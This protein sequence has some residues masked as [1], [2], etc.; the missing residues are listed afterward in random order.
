MRVAY[1]QADSGDISL[2]IPSTF[3]LDFRNDRAEVLAAEADGNPVLTKATYGKGTVYFCALPVELAMSQQPGVS[4]TPDQ[5]PYW[6]MYET[7]SQEVRNARVLHVEEPHIGITE[8]PSMRI[9][10]LQS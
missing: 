5:F 3:K 10:R 8:H 6:K 2:T 4:Y 1:L 9:Q 7:I